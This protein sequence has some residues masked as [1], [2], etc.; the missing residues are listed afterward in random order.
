METMIRWSIFAKLKLSLIWSKTSFPRRSCGLTLQRVTTTR[1]TWIQ[2]TGRNTLVRRWSSYQATGY[3]DRS[4]YASDGELLTGCLIGTTFTCGVVW[5]DH[6]RHTLD[7]QREPLLIVPLT[8]TT[9]PHVVVSAA[10]YWRNA[11]L[12]V[13]DRHRKSAL[14]LAH[15]LLFCPPY[16]IRP[17]PSRPDI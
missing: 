9:S 16:S 7:R 15:S 3:S 2:R 12:P 8:G 14:S 4:R 11:W 13:R 6:F 17:L 10:V 5:R 1:L